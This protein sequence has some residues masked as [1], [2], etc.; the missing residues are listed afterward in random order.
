[1]Q[2]RDVESNEIGNYAIPLLPP[3]LY[4]VSVEQTGFHYSVQTNIK[5]AVNQVVRVD[6]ILQVGAVTEKVV[7]TDSLPRLQ[8]DTSALGQVVDE[9]KVVELPI[10]QRNF[11]AFALLVPGAHAAT[12]GSTNTTSRGALSVHGARDDANNFL[13]NG[14]DNN[15][16][17]FNQLTVLPSID[18]IQEFKVQSSNSSAEFGRSA[19]AQINVVLKER[20]ERFTRDGFR[21]RSQ[22][23]PRCQEFLRPARLYTRFGA[24][25]LRRNPSL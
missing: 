13:L 12:D 18:A 3:G 15:Y 4:E 21:V 14:T 1:M 24:G 25:H 19:G 8:A 9:Q 2:T 23:K 17:V 10:N 11:L 6:V 20:D 7:V 5:V 16:K 22:P